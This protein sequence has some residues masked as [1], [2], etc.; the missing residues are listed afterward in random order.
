MSGIV[1]DYGGDIETILPV[2]NSLMEM[3]VNKKSLN[4]LQIHGF[5]PSMYIIMGE[6]CA[7]VCQ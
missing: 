1:E 6:L 4:G 2:T 3:F 5:G 7:P